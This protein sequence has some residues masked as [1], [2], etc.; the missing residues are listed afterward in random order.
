MRPA[1][2][3]IRVS[4]SVNCEKC[5]SKTVGALGIDRSTQRRESLDQFHL[6]GEDAPVNSVIA[7]VVA[8]QREAWL[9]P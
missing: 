5:R 9:P 1:A 3:N 4:P 2:S 8:R 7:T 6:S